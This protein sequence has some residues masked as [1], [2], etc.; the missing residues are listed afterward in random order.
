MFYIFYQGKL[1][2]ELTVQDVFRSEQHLR[3]VDDKA[4]HMQLFHMP[5]KNHDCIAPR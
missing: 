5:K 1:S 4:E 2:S 3:V